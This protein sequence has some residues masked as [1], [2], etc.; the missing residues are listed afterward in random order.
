LG[1]SPWWLGLCRD[2][3]IPARTAI[4][5]I[6]TRSLRTDSGKLLPVS[7]H[8]TLCSRPD[9]TPSKPRP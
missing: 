8:K 6:I 5:H 2:S 9:K 7:V 4:A 1:L 3:R